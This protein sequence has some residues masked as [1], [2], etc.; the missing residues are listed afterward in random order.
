MLMKLTIGVQF[1][2]IFTQSFLCAQIQKHEKTVNQAIDINNWIV[3][4]LSWC[5]KIFTSSL[6]DRPVLSNGPYAK[7]RMEIYSS[8][9]P[10]KLGAIPVIRDTRRG[11]ADPRGVYVSKPVSLNDIGEGGV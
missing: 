9:I 1:T 4:R 10:G 6:I 8:I 5:R 3:S 7:W 11:V 2:N